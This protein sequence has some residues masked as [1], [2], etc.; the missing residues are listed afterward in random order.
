VLGGLAVA[1]TTTSTRATADEDLQADQLDDGGV[2]PEGEEDEGEDE[3]E[4]VPEVSIADLEAALRELVAAV[5]EAKE[6][7]LDAVELV[8]ERGLLRDLRSYVLAFRA[9]RLEREHDGV[10]RLFAAMEERFA[11]DADAYAEVLAVHVADGRW[12]LVLDVFA[13]MKAREVTP[14]LVCYNCAMTAYQATMYWQGANRLLTEMKENDVQPDRSSYLRALLSCNKKKDGE[15][16]LTIMRTMRQEDV[17][18]D[19]ECY[20]AAIKACGGSGLYEEGVKLCLQMLDE[21]LRLDQDTLV[22]MFRLCRLSGNPAQALDFL[23]RAEAAKG[24]E[25]TDLHYDMVISACE[26]AGEWQQVVGV[27]ARMGARGISPHEISCNS[28]LRACVNIGEWQVARNLLSSMESNDTDLDEIAYATVLRGCVAAEQ[29]DQAID[30]FEHVRERSPSLVCRD[31]VMPAIAALVEAG[32]PDDGEA[33]YRESV[34]S[35]YFQL[36]R[37][38][39][40]GGGPALLDAK[41]LLPQVAGVAVRVAIK[42]A[43][44]AKDLSRSGKLVALAGFPAPGAQDILVV[45]GEDTIVDFDP[46]QAHGASPAAA[47]LQAA[48]ELLGD[49]VQLESTRNADCCIRIPGPELQRLGVKEAM[50]S[51]IPGAGPQSSG[52][53][54]DGPPG[55]M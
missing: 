12:A 26:R 36:W 43:E 22:Y 44:G 49:K 46:L 1:S 16:C 34:Q 35:G 50:A 37:R 23:K 20:L 14:N 45:V 18:P 39:R 15:V 55:S 38:A 6:A 41:A 2:F 42:D 47:V 17:A 52:S 24:A 51:F 5:R 4:L 10:L 19:Q 3:G 30:L 33:L 54:L 53:S 48:R 27:A 7:Q 32:R 9:L 31:I 40:L 25:L 28:V 13:Q 29:W 21:G 8:Q 11:A